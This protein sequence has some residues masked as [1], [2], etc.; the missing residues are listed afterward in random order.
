MI[1]HRQF[2][3]KYDLKKRNSFL[4]NETV[5]L[6]YNNIIELSHNNF[7]R[8]FSYTN[9]IY[10]GRNRYNRAPVRNILLFV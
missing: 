4:E 9:Y 7:M 3:K 1:Q 10:S 5:S 2:A 8:F 6:F